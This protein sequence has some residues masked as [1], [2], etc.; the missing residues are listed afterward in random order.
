MEEE[1]ALQGKSE[2]PYSMA[3]GSLVHLEMYTDLST[4]ST[5]FIFGAL[6]HDI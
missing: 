6:T 2:T 3:L 4:A 5:L 1:R